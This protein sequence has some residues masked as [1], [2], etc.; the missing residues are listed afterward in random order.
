MWKIIATHKLGDMQ[1]VY[2]MDS[3]TE[4]PELVL[5]PA[6]MEY[7][8]AKREKPYGDSLVQI[9]IAGDTYPGGYAGG[10]TLR[11]GQSVLDFCYQAQEVTRHNGKTDVCTILKDKRNYKIKHHLTFRE[12][13]KSLRCNL[14]LRMTKK[15]KNEK[16]RKIP[17]NAENKPFLRK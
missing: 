13:D 6:D 1:A 14:S 8:E 12:G 3:E 16:S 11:Q 15:Q 7:R 17:K 10:R 5:L 9:K 2:G 4:N